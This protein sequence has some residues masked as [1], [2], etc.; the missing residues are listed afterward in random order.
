MAVR[1][2]NI[3]VWHEEVSRG[4]QNI[5]SCTLKYIL[6]LLRTVTYNEAFSDDSEE[7]NKSKLI[8]ELWMFIVMIT[9]SETIDHKFLLIN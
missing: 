7:Q 1:L 6:Q 4:S 5:T 2:V 8:I 9:D 3:Y